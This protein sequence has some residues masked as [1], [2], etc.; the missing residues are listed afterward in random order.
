M[1]AH[2]QAP[3]IRL[4]NPL[5]G[6]K[7]RGAD[8]AL[9]NPQFAG[10]C[11]GEEKRQQREMVLRGGIARI[12]SEREGKVCSSTACMNG[13]DQLNLKSLGL[14][15]YDC[16]NTTRCKGP[17]RTRNL[18]VQQRGVARQSGGKMQKILPRTPCLA[19][20]SRLPSSYPASTSIS[21]NKGS[22]KHRGIRGNN[23][24]NPSYIGN[25]FSR[26]RIP[27]DAAVCAVE[28]YICFRKCPSGLLK[29]LI[30]VRNIWDW[31]LGMCLPRV[32]IYQQQ[33]K[34]Q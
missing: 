8:F 18:R 24:V 15:G 34:K 23:Q 6:E 2:V 17:V 27:G 14:L 19:S 12:V 16:G 11:S 28:H 3:W 1:D 21:V 30:E 33:Q 5:F 25:C 22:S 9:T 29:S 4:V 13:C 20:V 7:R 10:A 26:I 32:Q 31:E